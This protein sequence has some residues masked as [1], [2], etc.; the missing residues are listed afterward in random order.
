MDS[1]SAALS[2]VLDQLASV[3][4]QDWPVDKIISSLH[5]F[6]P[7]HRSWEN[8]PRY[9][10]RARK[11]GRMPVYDRVFTPDDAVE[12]VNARW[13]RSSPDQTCWA[14][15]VSLMPHVPPEQRPIIIYPQSSFCTPPCNAVEFFVVPKRTVSAQTYEYAGFLPDKAAWLFQQY[16]LHLAQPPSTD[17]KETFESFALTYVDEFDVDDIS[18]ERPD[19]EAA[20]FER[21]GIS[22]TV[23]NCW[24]TLFIQPTDEHLVDKHPRSWFICVFSMA[25]WFLDDLGDLSRER[26][27]R[28][29]SLS[30]GYYQQTQSSSPPASQASSNQPFSSLEPPSEGSEPPYS[31][32]DSTSSP[33]ARPHSS[34]E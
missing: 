16:Q 14:V 34:E 23:A 11:T 12:L 13:L 10:I 26:S 15:A 33:D 24:K 6:S 30:A 9:S 7:L 19:F 20:Y 8:L 25:L 3:K 22:Q 5:P 1:F 17:P 4:A 28:R 2:T 27:M 29:S 21:V 32:S 18:P 31:S